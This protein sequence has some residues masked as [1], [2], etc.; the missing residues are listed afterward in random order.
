MELRD[1]KD[2]HTPAMSR[3]LPIRWCFSDPVVGSMMSV[4]PAAGYCWGDEGREIAAL[5]AQRRTNGVQPPPI[6]PAETLMAKP[7]ID[8]LKKND[9][10]VCAITT[11]RICVFVVDT[12]EVWQA[13]AMVNE[14]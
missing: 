10:S 11:L 13:A 2:L 3:P 14:K 5:A 6:M 12:S 8:A 7:R 1:S 4:C 9:T